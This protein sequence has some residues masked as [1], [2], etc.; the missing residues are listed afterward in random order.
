MSL[1]DQQNKVLADIKQTVYQYIITGILHAVKLMRVNL[2]VVP[3]LFI[4]SRMSKWTIKIK[5]YPNTYRLSIEHAC[6][7]A[8]FTNS[9]DV[10][11]LLKKIVL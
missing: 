4:I 3:K 10:M 7:C 1:V 9:Q 2:H 11:V 5:R 6:T 8:V